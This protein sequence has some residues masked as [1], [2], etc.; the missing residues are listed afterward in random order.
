MDS[1]QQ[2]RYLVG[3]R[4]PDEEIFS[5]FRNFTW[6]DHEFRSLSKRAL[7][8][9]LSS[10]KIF[11]GNK[12]LRNSRCYTKLNK[13]I[14]LLPSTFASNVGKTATVI[15]SL[16]LE[17]RD[18]LNSNENGIFSFKVSFHLTPILLPKRFFRSRR[19]LG[20]FAFNWEASLM[21]FVIIT[22]FRSES[23]FN[24]VPFAID[25]AYKYNAGM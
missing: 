23:F 4:D 21:F 8:T 2:A 17:W 9:L 19:T 1:G 3:T 22:Q 11:R 14:P 20:S 25:P 12:I 16:G 6:S 10:L 15:V 18:M 24:A 13:Y 5:F 7:S